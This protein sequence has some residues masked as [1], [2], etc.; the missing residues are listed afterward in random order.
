ASLAAHHGGVKVA[1]SG[2]GGDELFGGYPSFRALPRLNRLL[3]GW[4]RVP[5][6]LRNIILRRPRADPSTRD[7][8]LGHF[9]T[10]ARDLHELGALQRRVLAEPA[11]LALL[12]PDARREAE[13]LGPQHPMLDDFVAELDGADDFQIISAWELRTYMADVLLRDSDVFSM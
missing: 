12:A 7:H 1:L 13:R 9:L 8:K 4:R 3:P 6:P 2:L 11:R 10:H 5:S